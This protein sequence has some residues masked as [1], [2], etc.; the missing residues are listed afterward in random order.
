[1]PVYAGTRNAL[2]PRTIMTP[3]DISGLAFWVA[4]DFGTYQDTSRTTPATADGDPLGG[5][6]NR[7]PIS[8]IHPSQSSTSN[9]PT[10]RTNVVA[11]K[12]VIRFDG[13]DDDLI[14]DG[15]N[16]GSNTTWFFVVKP[17][18][19]SPIGIF[20]S[21]AGVGDV[22]RN[23]NSGQWD[24][25]DA[26]P[27][28]NLGLADTN[29]VLLEFRTRLT[30]TRE[31]VYHRNGTLVSVNTNAD[32]AAMAWGTVRLGSINGGG[33]GRYAGDLAEMVIY[34]RVLQSDEQETVRRLLKSKYGLP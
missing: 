3:A 25:H 20:D 18:S 17:S 10:L 7:A 15:L 24:W 12:P 2:R 1:M 4:A 27:Q 6:V 29:A 14:L 11:G 33:A 13:S 16:A 19:T 26:E 34:N 21:A 5:W 30:P 22:W 28:F 31:V 9:K 8:P 32:T 23:Y